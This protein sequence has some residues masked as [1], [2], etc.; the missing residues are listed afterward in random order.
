M[1]RPQNASQGILVDYL[2]VDAF[3]TV[4]NQ[5]EDIMGYPS[6]RVYL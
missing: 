5:L 1:M 4:T 2:P 3:Q 6:P